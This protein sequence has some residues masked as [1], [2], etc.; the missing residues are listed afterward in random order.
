M[1]YRGGRRLALHPSEITTLIGRA[2]KV[3]ATYQPIPGSRSAERWWQL[4]SLADDYGISLRTLY[5]YLHR[6][7]R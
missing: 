6:A 2:E 7:A 4:H 5:R 3:R 1:T